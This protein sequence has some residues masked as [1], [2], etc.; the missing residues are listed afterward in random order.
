MASKKSTKTEKVIKVTVGKDSH[1]VKGSN[2]PANFKQSDIPEDG[3]GFT[4]IK[5][6]ESGCG[7]YRLIHTQDAKQVTLCRAHQFAVVRGK[8]KAQSKVTL[9]C[10]RLIG[11]LHTTFPK[12]KSIKAENH[13]A[14]IMKIASS[15]SKKDISEVE[16]AITWAQ[17]AIETAKK[18]EK[19]QDAKGRKAQ[20][21]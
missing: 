12:S 16:Q 5:C 4:F 1:A 13:R 14:T 21:A 20:V 3:K 15:L 2:V 9:K 11:R 6:T 19:K 7:E 10:R 17:S 8:R 18:T